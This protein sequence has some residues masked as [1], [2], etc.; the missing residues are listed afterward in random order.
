MRKMKTIL[1]NLNCVI[2]WSQSDK[3]EKKFAH[4]S[5]YA[6]IFEMKCEYH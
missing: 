2:K 5:C 4:L 1:S 6:F 3:R